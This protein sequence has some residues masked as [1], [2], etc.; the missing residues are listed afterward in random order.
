ME[1][2]ILRVS[3]KVSVKRFG[4]HLLCKR[5]EV[6]MLPWTFQKSNSFSRIVV[7]DI[8]FHI[9]VMKSYLPLMA[10]T[11]ICGNNNSRNS[12]KQKIKMEVLVK[13][14]RWWLNI[15][16]TSRKNGAID[17]LLERIADD[18]FKFYF[19]FF[20]NMAWHLMG[21]VCWQMM[22]MI[23]AMARKPVFGISV[24]ANLKPVSSATETN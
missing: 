23:W 18:I 14:Q 1:S 24:K 12:R 17:I 3:C 2:W 20:A 22:H 8:L 5:P 11:V 16:D 13:L 7:T 15:T 4:L 10:P 9:S 19:C 21:I 6:F